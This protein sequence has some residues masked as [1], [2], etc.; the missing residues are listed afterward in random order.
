MTPKHLVVSA[1]ACA[2]TAIAGYF[3]RPVVEQVAQQPAPPILIAAPVG[4]MAGQPWA[5]VQPQQ[6]AAPQVLAGAAAR[7]NRVELVDSAGR[8]ICVLGVDDNGGTYLWLNVNGQA[9][10]LDLAALAKKLG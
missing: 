2:I 1:V 6:P 3:G 10:R 9:K 4:P 5:A 8:L 7:V